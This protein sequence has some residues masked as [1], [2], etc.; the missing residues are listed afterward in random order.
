MYATSFY[1][2]IQG[3][4]LYMPTVLDGRRHISITQPVL[5]LALDDYFSSP[6]QDCLARLFDAIN[7]MDLSAAPILTRSEKIIMRNSERKD[8]FIEK[9][10]SPRASSEASQHLK[11]KGNHRPMNS[12]GSHSSFD[13]GIMIRTKNSEEGRG[14]ASSETSTRVPSVSSHHNGTQQYSPSEASS[15][16]L[17]GSAVWVGEEGTLVDHGSSNGV[18]SSHGSHGSSSVATKGG[19]RST[20]ASSS[21]S[22]GPHSRPPI[23]A[24]MSDLRL[25]TKDTHFYHTTIDYKS[26]QLP[27]KMPLFTFPQEV[28]DVSVPDR[29]RGTAI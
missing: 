6:S 16:T 18:A 1:S 23:N 10:T 4:P 19:R 5:L 24:G 8:V 11:G 7:S 28:G 25:G 2:D 20:D 14:R 29:Q 13:E 15:F 27:I 17:G 22:H 26:H 9:F 3:A 21:S 12:T